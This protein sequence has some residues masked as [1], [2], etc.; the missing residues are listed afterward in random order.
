MHLPKMGVDRTLTPTPTPTLTYTPTPTPTNTPTNTP[1]PT[2]TPTPTPTNTPTNTPTPTPTPA[3]KIYYGSLFGA[4]DLY[5]LDIGGKWRQSVS[6]RFRAIT[7]DRLRSIRVFF[8]DNRNAP[9]YASGSGGK[10]LIQVFA[11]SGTANHEPS[12]AALTAI[13]FSPNYVGGKDP[14]GTSG[15]FRSLEFGE[16]ITLSAG[17]LYHVVFSNVDPSPTNNYLGIDNNIVFNGESQPTI[18]TLDLGLLF[19]DKTTSGWG[20]A[21]RN[22]ASI[23]PSSM[24][25]IISLSYLSGRTQGDGYMEVWWQQPRYVSGVQGVREIFTPT[26]TIK[27]LRTISIRL[28]RLSGDIA[29][30]IRVT[31]LDG[32]LVAQTDIPASAIKLNRHDWATGVFAAPFDLALGTQYFLSLASVG[33]YEVIAIRDGGAFGFGRETTFSDGYVQFN[34]GDGKGWQGWYGWSYEGAPNQVFGDLQFYLSD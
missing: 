31:R 22:F 23:K 12:G 2:P 20:D 26:K 9:G 4:G 10:I 24:S 5:N 8:T 15:I 3:L 34:R 18:T 6:I 16:P 14:L 17:S 33:N 7:T 28:K 13:N 29:L 27:A 19:R 21:S 30:S 32:S 25:P 11:D 1:A